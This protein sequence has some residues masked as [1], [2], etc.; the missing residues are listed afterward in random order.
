MHWAEPL[1]LL[2]LAAT[3]L[4]FLAR[5]GRG[6]VVWPSISGYFDGTRG[7]WARLDR[8]IPWLEALA[9]T[10]LALALARPQTV[11]GRTKVV[12]RG[13]A[14]VVVLDRSS[15][16]NAADFTV[17]GQA[18]ATR[19]DSAKV[20]LAQFVE[21][22][23]GDLVGLVSFADQPDLTC[24]PTLDHRFVLDAI[25]NLKTA[26]AD[27]DG[28][29]LSDAILWGADALRKTSAKVKRLV[30]LSDGRHA[31]QARKGQTPMPPVEAAKIARALGLVVDTV[32]IGG[33]GGLIRERRPE[34]DLDL[35][36]EVGGPDL[37]TLREIAR[38][39]GGV[40]VHARNAR[41]LS[42]AFDRIDDA[43]KSR[44]EELVATRYDDRYAPFATV[45]A[46][47]LASVVVFRA[48]R[49]RR[50]P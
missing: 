41:E 11:A 1:W 39:G 30:L 17:P 24:A 33:E 27:D 23:P 44:F 32:A 26:R 43:D 42:E 47:L 7:I 18:S 46:A 25:R 22:R 31:P 38:E 21:G 10:A 34:F 36:N 29:N 15:S 19:L 35:V 14:V 5:W 40:A 3:P 4:P 28:T 37:V 8:L 45:A 50:L 16:M 12:G 13:V 20:R 49:G 2:L 9:I 48:G 6:G